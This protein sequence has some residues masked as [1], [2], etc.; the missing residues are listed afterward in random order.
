MLIAFVVWWIYGRQLDTVVSST[1]SDVAVAQATQPSSESVPHSKTPMPSESINQ[2]THYEVVNGEPITPSID[3]RM[4]AIESEALIERIEKLVINFSELEKNLSTW[5]QRIS[6][7]AS[8]DTGRRLANHPTTLGLVETLM[9]SDPVPANQFMV[10]K[11]RIRIIEEETAQVQTQRIPDGLEKMIAETKSMVDRYTDSLAQVSLSM[12]TFE[13]QSLLENPSSMTLADAIIKR[14]AELAI[15][16]AKRLDDD[17]TQ[18]DEKVAAMN[19]EAAAFEHQRKIQIA[20]EQIDLAKQ[21]LVDEQEK[22]RLEAAKRKLEAEFQRDLPQIKHYLGKLFV[23]GHTQP[24]SSTTYADVGTTGPVSLARLVAAGALKDKVE[25]DGAYSAILHLMVS[26]TND[27]KVAAPY[28]QNYI[29][30]YPKPAEAAAARP[31]YLLLK[32]Y[33]QLLV[34]KGYLGK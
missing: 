27:R 1:N 30:G 17:K 16:H 23:D 7:L 2:P 4:R 12:D 14:N 29:G 9:L 31:A 6:D 13:K 32:K 5:N 10:L 25:G 8:N 11:K 24:V 3:E 21:R 15:A 20:G 28:P 22:L 34:E 33:G 19:R 18:A 26:P